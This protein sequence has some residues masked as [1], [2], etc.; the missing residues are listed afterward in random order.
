[1]ENTLL[2]LKKETCAVLRNGKHGLGCGD[3]LRLAGSR[4]QEIIL[5]ALAESP[6]TP[7][8]LAA[9][10]E[11]DGGITDSGEAALEIAAFILDFKDFIE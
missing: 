4:Q 2:A 9:M 5:K 7:E 6:R 10:L 11:R 1:M 3:R 8:E